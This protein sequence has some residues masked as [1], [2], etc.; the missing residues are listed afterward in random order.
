MAAFFTRYLKVRIAMPL[1]AQQL[2]TC[3]TSVSHV[4]PCGFCFVISP[5]CGRSRR[6][7]WSDQLIL[8]K[9]CVLTFCGFRFPCGQISPVDAKITVFGEVRDGDKVDQIKVAFSQLDS[10]VAQVA[11]L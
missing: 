10:I 7:K 5:A 8:D 2:A 1:C 3:R 9:T 4:S 6:P 11:Q